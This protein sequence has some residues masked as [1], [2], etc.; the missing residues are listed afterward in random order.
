MRAVGENAHGF[1]ANAT[2]TVNVPVQALY[3]AFMD[4]A[5]RDR[6]LGDVELEIRT[7]TE[8]KGARF[9]WGDGCT[10][11]IVGFEPK[12]EAKSVVAVS[13]ERLRD[14]GEAERM[15][16]LWRAALTAFKAQL[17]SDGAVFVI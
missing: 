15:K 3:E 14:A 13:H 5:L 16:A 2:R 10:R 4:E 9:N 11:V 17:E 1:T 6:W 12:G 7:A 8:P